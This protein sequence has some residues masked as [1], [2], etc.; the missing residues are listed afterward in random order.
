MAKLLHDAASVRKRVREAA[1]EAEED[2][3]SP[4]PLVA[5]AGKKSKVI[6]EEGAPLR[7]DSTGRSNNSN[8][9]GRG[10][11]SA[12]QQNT[13]YLGHIPKGFE[14][15][16]MR[17]FFSQFGNVSNLKL[18][19]SARTDASKG[20]AFIQ[21]DTEECAATVAEAMNGYFLGN[22]TLVSHV[23]PTAKMHDG[24][25]KPYPKKNKKG[26][27]V[28]DAGDD[29]VYAPAEGVVPPEEDPAELTEA[30][31]KKAIQRLKKSQRKLTSMGIDISFLGRL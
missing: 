31:K 19:R 29:L 21:F 10:S 23:V 9:V 4:S 5:K 15:K 8:G 1:A 28:A 27:D 13:I 17:K 25:F 16:E 30:Q 22:R 7:K 24:M 14:E 11:N 18:F 6:R 26:N 3:R 20:Y 12:P 2:D